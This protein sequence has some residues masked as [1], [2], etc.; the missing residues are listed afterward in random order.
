MKFYYLSP[1]NFHSFTHN[2]KFSVDGWGKNIIVNKREAII[3][4]N[5]SPVGFDQQVLPAI[6]GIRN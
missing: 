6:T 4:E 5:W 1:Q 2:L 3:W